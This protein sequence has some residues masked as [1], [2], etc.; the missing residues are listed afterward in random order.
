MKLRLLPIAIFVATAL[1]VV[2]VSALWQGVETFV[3]MT[4]SSRPAAAQANA[5][6]PT[7]SQPGKSVV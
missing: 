4:I 7:A 3:N 1:L 5:P 2:K 6:A